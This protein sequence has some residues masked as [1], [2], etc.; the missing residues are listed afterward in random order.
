M[1]CDRTMISEMT[2]AGVSGYILKNTGKQELIN[3]L[4]KISTGGR[5]FSDE[6]AEEIMKAYSE[7]Q[8]PNKE[9]ANEVHLTEREKE[10]V[11]L[12]AKEFSNVQIADKLFISERTVESH[13]KNI[14][15]KTNTKSVVGLIKFAYDKKMIS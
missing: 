6:V 9:K 15:R 5:Y 13:R 7:N 11:L 8:K 3:A 14:F 2:D 4:L 10:I 12:I 1:H